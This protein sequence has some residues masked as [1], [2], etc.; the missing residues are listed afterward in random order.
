MYLVPFSP[1]FNFCPP[2]SIINPVR[3]SL[4]HIKQLLRHPQTK[5]FKF[6]LKTLSMIQIVPSNV[7]LYKKLLQY[8]V[9][10]INFFKNFY[11]GLYS[12]QQCH[13]AL[14]LLLSNINLRQF[15]K[16]NFIYLC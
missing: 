8:N 1:F 2:K 3:K 14:K 12:T 6:F 4:L 9:S 5:K 15:L 13:I 11:F 7:Y 10:N 16:N